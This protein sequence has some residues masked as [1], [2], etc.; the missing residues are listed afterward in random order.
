V[1]SKKDAITQL[2][3]NKNKSSDEEIKVSLNTGIKEYINKGDTEVC[4]PEKKDM[5]KVSFDF[6]KDF[7]T[8]LKIFAATKNKSML[9]IVVEATKKYMSEN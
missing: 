7:H 2:L 8:E 4:L 9:D 6:D 5:K 3:G 1:S